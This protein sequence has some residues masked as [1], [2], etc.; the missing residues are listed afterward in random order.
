MPKKWVAG[1]HIQAHSIGGRC[2]DRTLINRW[3]RMKGKI[4]GECM[5]VSLLTIGINHMKGTT[6]FTNHFLH[7]YT[8]F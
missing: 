4:E 5:Y 7:K 1:A 8:G 6:S 2:I 3:G